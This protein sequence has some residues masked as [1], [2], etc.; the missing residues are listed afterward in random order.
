MGSW[1]SRVSTQLF[2]AASYIREGPWRA[3]TEEQALAETHRPTADAMHY[4][5]AIWAKCNVDSTEPYDVLIAAGE[6][7]KED[8]Q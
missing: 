1:D 7:A 4:I 5:R 8:G 6:L 3:L 2:E